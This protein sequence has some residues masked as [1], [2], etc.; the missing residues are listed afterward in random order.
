MTRGRFRWIFL[1]G[2]IL[3]LIAIAT[4]FVGIDLGVAALLCILP[5]EHAFVQAGQAVPLA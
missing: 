3:N 2:I 1:A 5:L 4:P